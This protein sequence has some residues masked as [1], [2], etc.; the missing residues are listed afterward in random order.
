MCLARKT[1]VGG[2][3]TATQ[4]DQKRF[5]DV[6]MTKVATRWRHTTGLQKNGRIYYIFFFLKGTKRLRCKQNV[7]IDI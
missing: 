7:M 1:V 2:D 5:F 4:V 3:S 6:T